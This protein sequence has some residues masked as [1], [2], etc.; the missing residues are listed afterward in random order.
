MI[1]SLAK[2]F[3]NLTLF[4]AGLMPMLWLWLHYTLYN[5]LLVGIPLPSYNRV[6]ESGWMGM[7]RHLGKIINKFDYRTGH[8]GCG[9]YEVMSCTL[10]CFHSY[11]RLKLTF[12]IFA[13]NKFEYGCEK[14]NILCF[15]KRCKMQNF[16]ENNVKTAEI[17]FKNIVTPFFYLVFG[18]KCF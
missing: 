7:E 16:D 8:L 9:H 11:P 3:D 4:V 5:V 6:K 10:G 18:L 13:I 15:F 2:T 17:F 1:Q 12:T 14:P